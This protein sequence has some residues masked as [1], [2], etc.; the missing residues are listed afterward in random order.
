MEEKNKNIILRVDADLHKRVKLYTT[1]NN[2][3]IQKYI[4]NLIEND[5]KKEKENLIKK[6]EEIKHG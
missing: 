2:I 4:V 5:M 3:S 1:L 6:V